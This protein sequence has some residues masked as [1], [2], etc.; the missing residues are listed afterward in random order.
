MMNFPLFCGEID[1]DF[2]N[3]KENIPQQRDIFFFKFDFQFSP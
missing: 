2:E 3:E 1:R